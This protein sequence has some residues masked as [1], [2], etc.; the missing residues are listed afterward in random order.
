[1]LL[2]THRRKHR[3]DLIFKYISNRAGIILRYDLNLIGLQDLL[4]LKT[5]LSANLLYTSERID[6]SILEIILLTNRLVELKRFYTQKLQLA[7]V[8]ETATRFT[9]LVGASALTFE[10]GGF[11]EPFYHFAF[12]IPENQ[13]PEAITWLSK[14]GLELL[15]DQNS[16]QIH[17]KSWNAHAVY[18]YDSAGNIVECIARHKLKNASDRPFDSSA[19][20]EISELG[21][22][23]QNVAML[24]KWLKREVGLVKWAGDGKSFNALGDE[25]GLFIVVNN[26]RNWFPTDRPAKIYPAQIV[27]RGDDIASLVC[28]SEPYSIHRTLRMF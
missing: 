5:I 4:G 20:L 3:R 12:N 1:M 14:Q 9:V 6:M 11:G 21:L 27:L 17:F 22:P 10:A 8:D 19:F 25:R 7:L 13:L 18:F 2:K 28:T 16:A 15:R 23:C 26:G 24:S